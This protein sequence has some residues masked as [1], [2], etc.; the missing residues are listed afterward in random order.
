MQIFY[1]EFCVWWFVGLIVQNTSN[2]HGLPVV[3]RNLFA[4]ETE[5]HIIY[6]PQALVY[7]VQPSSNHCH[8][9]LNAIGLWNCQLTVGAQTAGCKFAPDIS[10]YIIIRVLL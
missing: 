8:N 3:D 1:T 6:T 2:S 5:R 9:W 7:N 10:N 4:H